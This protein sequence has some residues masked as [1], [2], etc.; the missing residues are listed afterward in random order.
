MDKLGFIKVLKDSGYNVDPSASIPTIF[1]A[2]SELKK[3]LRD[4]HRLMKESD[5]NESFKVDMHT[6]KGIP[7]AEADDLPEQDIAEDSFGDNDCVVAESGPVA[8][9]D[10]QYESNERPAEDERELVSVGAIDSEFFIP[11][12]TDF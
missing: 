8:I 2:K 7:A 1:A 5:Y 3:I 11:W 6:L 4:I 12:S 10:V 9:E